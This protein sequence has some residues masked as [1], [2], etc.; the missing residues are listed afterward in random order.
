MFAADTTG[1]VLVELG[2][3]L[4][5]LAALGRLAARVG[6]PSIPLY[7][8]AG[9]L[10]GEGG[11]VSLDASTD[12][13]QVAADIGLVLL[14]LLLGLEY[15]PEELTSGL[16]ANWTAGLVDLVTSFTP[17]WLMGMLLGWSQPAAVLLGGVTYI[18]SSG[19]IAKLLSDLDR[20]ANRETPVVLAILV[21]EDIVMAVFLPLTGVLLVG[22]SP[23]EGA[24]SIVVALLVVAAAFFVALRWSSPLSRLLDTHSPELLLLTVLGLTLLV[25][26]LA[27]EL[28]ISAAVGAFLLGLMLSGQIAERGRELLAPIRDVF[29][30]LFFVFFGLQVDPGTLGPALVPALVLAVVTSAS[31]IGTGWWAARRAG[32]GIPGRKRAA[33][34]LVPRG[35]FSIVIAGLGVSVGAEPDLGPTAASYVLIVAIT[36]SMAMRFVDGRVRSTRF[37]RGWRT[38]VRGDP[39]APAGQVRPS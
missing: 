38:R 15:Q 5:L 32:I 1:T 37:A 23:L 36:G 18:S 34:A 7:L 28:Q 14:L 10:L 8:V 25:A 2:A 21:I 24:V 17:G 26:G 4:L 16:R 39:V 27:D 12:F 30:G 11:A 33:V 31:K 29:G 13:I 20:L 6:L 35:E 9:L 22:A 19:I 3:L